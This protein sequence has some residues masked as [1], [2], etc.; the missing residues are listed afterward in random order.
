METI[1]AIQ[2]RRSI[3]KVLD[4]EPDRALIE[5]ILDAAR[6]AP[7]HMNTEPWHFT[8]LTGEGRNR[9]GNVLG[10][11]NQQKLKDASETTLNDALASGIAKAKRAPVV[12]VVTVEPSD[13]P[14]VFEIEEIAATAAAVEN[15]LL[16]A[17]SLGLGAMWRTGAPTYTAE[18]K[19]EF[20]ESKRSLILGFIY[21]G[22]PD[23]NQKTTIP[24]R[25][26]VDQ[27]TTWVNE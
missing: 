22:Y 4:K 2:T 1:D 27:V 16:A 20:G 11:L 10:R 17:H 21:I 18:M 19:N 25:K 24:D 6:K 9:L 7:N 12:I 5:K 15:M 3:R 14:K 26:T 13:N 8:V 23:P